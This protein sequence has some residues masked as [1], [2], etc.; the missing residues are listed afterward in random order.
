M[1]RNVQN[2][3]KGENETEAGSKKKRLTSPD[4]LGHRTGGAFLACCW[5]VPPR[6]SPR[7]KGSER[8]STGSG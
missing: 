5:S 3:G 4:D 2:R 1:C 8:A 6:W 7:H